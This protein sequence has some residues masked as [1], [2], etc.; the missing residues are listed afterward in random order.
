MLRTHWKS[1]AVATGLSMLARLSG[2]LSAV[3]I[4]GLFGIGLHTD[5]YYLALAPALFITTVISGGA[6]TALMPKLLTPG[7]T[8]N[9]ELSLLS[10]VAFGLL[11]AGFSL[12]ALL[13]VVG[14]PLMG[15]IAGHY[16][17]DTVDLV[18]LLTAAMV[19]FVLF[20]ILA[21]LLATFL[22][23]KKAY[24]AVISVP[25]ISPAVTVLCG[26][27]LSEQ[28]GVLSLA[29]GQSLGAMLE[30]LILASLVNKEKA[31][32][33]RI[34]SPA[35]FKLHF[36]EILAVAKHG[37]VISAGLVMV[38]AVALVDQ[39]FAASAGPGALSEYT[40]GTKLF[41]VVYAV[42][43]TVVAT[44]VMPRI[45]ER[46][47]NKDW[48]G[49]SSMLKKVTLELALLASLTSL[50]L[51]VLSDQLTKVL[52]VR[53]AFTLENAFAAS[54][55]NTW[56]VWSLPFIMLA[57]VLSRTANAVGLTSLAVMSSAV[58]LVVKVAGNVMLVPI[59]GAQGIAMA[60]VIAYAA[61]FL[62]LAH[63]FAKKF[64][65]SAI[66]QNPAL[67][68]KIPSPAKQ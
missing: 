34:P 21:Q 61:C 18:V 57:S 48:R 25:A 7:R 33:F 3:V 38:A 2:A 54:A 1:A 32:E 63:P 41:S 60:S 53:G 24:R 40:Y 64:A 12:Y 6:L 36:Q 67:S 42:F 31:A 47:M 27:L 46:A 20:S 51:A 8:K 35:A 16:P 4:A 13:L 9:E 30:L 29:L 43:T 14:K 62:S 5:A 26:G 49:F 15:L 28:L 10:G 44:L 37:S 11:V 17:K 50:A 66:Q 45:I 56:L 22:T 52:F 39:I 68:E 58:L 55:V 59:F 23:A 19:P 65:T